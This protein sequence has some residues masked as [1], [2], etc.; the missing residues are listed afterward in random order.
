MGTNL[1]L[2]LS[3]ARKNLEHILLT[4]LG[5]GDKYGGLL[6]QPR[7]LIQAVCLSNSS[8]SSPSR[9][10]KAVSRRLLRVS[11]ASGKVSLSV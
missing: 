2:T 3:I 11:V 7:F 5:F 6:D 9:L 1:P 4:N 8:L 10:L